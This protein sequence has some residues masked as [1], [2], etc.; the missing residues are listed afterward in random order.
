MMVVT[1]F[2]YGHRSGGAGDWEKESVA[3]RPSLSGR[4]A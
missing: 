1:E 4:N 3:F 2:S